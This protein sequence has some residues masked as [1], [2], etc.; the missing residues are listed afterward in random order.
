MTE[1]SHQQKGRNQN[2]DGLD[3]PCCAAVVTGSA[4]FTGMHKRY[5]IYEISGLLHEPQGLWKQQNLRASVHRKLSQPC[6]SNQ[7][8]H[9]RYLSSEA[10]CDWT[11]HSQL[12]IPWVCM[13]GLMIHDVS[14]ALETPAAGVKLPGRQANPVQQSNSGQTPAVTQDSLQAWS[15]LQDMNWGD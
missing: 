8:I 12:K 11:E 13:E 10:F 9:S 6:W 15:S 5:S 3:A 14:N 1:T 2:G 4:K 7:S